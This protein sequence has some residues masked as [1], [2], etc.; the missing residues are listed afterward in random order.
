M[1][2]GDLVLVKEVAIA[3][4]PIENRSVGPGDGFRISRIDG[5]GIL[6]YHTNQGFDQCIN[7]RSVEPFYQL[8]EELEAKEAVGPLEAGDRITVS[9]ILDDGYII[10]FDLRGKMQ[11]I[12]THFLQRSSVKVCVCPINQL[13]IGGCTCGGR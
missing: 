11:R 7:V 9:G 4:H 2:V 8:G 13:M 5:D 12:R 10:S 1:K 6:W 3:R